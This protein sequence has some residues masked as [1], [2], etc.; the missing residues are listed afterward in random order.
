MMWLH[1]SWEKGG[2]SLP[3]GYEVAWW[4]ARDLWYG[5]ILAAFALLV[6]VKVRARR[7]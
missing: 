1:K 6:W 7:F 2:F 5:C 4:F 3:F